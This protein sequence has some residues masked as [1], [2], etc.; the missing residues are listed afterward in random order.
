MYE[1]VRTRT[2]SH[3]L[4]LQIVCVIKITTLTNRQYAVIVNPIG[5]DG[6]PQLGKRKLIRGEKSLYL[7]PGEALERGIQDIYV[8]GEDEGLI[9]RASEAFKDADLVGRASDASN[10][11][12]QRVQ[13]VNRAPGD[14]WMIRGPTEYVPPVEV[15]VVARRTAIP[16]DENE[17]VY[18]RD[19]KTGRVRAVIGQT[20]MLTQVTEHELRA[21][22]SEKWCCCVYFMWDLYWLANLS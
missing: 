4:F 15:E 2:L 1:E 14:R 10:E 21:R 22:A 17:G 9:L 5:Q 20:Y 3:Y 16:L 19:I 18:I 13:N 6:R 12:Q 8:L 7:Q 11:Q